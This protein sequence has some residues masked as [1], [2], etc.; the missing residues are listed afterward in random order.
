MKRVNINRDSACFFTGHRRLPQNRLERIKR[1]LKLKI[2]DMIEYRGV[3]RFIAGGALG[4][5][6]LAA[7]TV[8]DLKPEYPNV[9]LYLYLPCFNQSE[10]W[11]DADKYKWHMMMT[12][13]DDYIYITQ[14]NY[15]SDCMRKRNFKMAD[16]AANCIAYCVLSK[17]GT[18]ATLVYAERRGCLIDNIA[19]DIY[20]EI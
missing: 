19:D 18:G 3:D 14:G 12:K 16:D 6:T 7:Q 2:K 15:T 1:L 11:N 4:F 13:V 9:K 5:D 17:S 10:R 8:I 20:S